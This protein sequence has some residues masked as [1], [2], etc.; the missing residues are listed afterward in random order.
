[1]LRLDG[2]GGDLWGLWKGRPSSEGCRAGER[3]LKGWARGI[4]TSA[5]CGC[6]DVEFDEA[7]GFS[8]FGR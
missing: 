8:H 5:D 7:H 1:M 3:L 2:S 6:C 4:L